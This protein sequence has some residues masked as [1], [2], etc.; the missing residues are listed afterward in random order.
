MG[1]AQYGR[2]L[3]LT[4]LDQLRFKMKILFKC[5][6]KQ[7]TLLRRSTVLSLFPKLVF[8]DLSLI[9]RLGASLVSVSAAYLRGVP[10]SAQL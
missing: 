4:S 3:V 10:Y 2:P 8:P 6:T 5:F 7:A 9:I 1:K